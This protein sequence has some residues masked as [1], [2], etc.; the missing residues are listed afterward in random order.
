MDSCANSGKRTAPFSPPTGRR[1]TA[2]S[3]LWEAESTRRLWAAKKSAPKM[4][5]ATAARTKGS[6]GKTLPPKQSA[7]LT[8]PQ[9]AIPIP[10]APT[11]A[12]PDAKLGD[13]ELGRTL[14]AAPVSA[15]KRRPDSES[16]R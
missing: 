3:M 2:S 9:E 16:V 14:T 1:D 15:K 10:S 13:A 5:L 8:T 7:I 4:G 11:R 12:G 6:S